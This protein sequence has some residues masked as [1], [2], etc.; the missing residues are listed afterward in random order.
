MNI[1]RN[2]GSKIFKIN[3]INYFEKIG[4]INHLAYKITNLVI[5]KQNE[6]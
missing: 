2:M 6:L 3:V 1:N 5:N 4:H